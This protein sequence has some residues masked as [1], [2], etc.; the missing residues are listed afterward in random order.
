MLQR[1]GCNLGRQKR[2][3]TNCNITCW[4]IT[5]RPNNPFPMANDKNWAI[6]CDCINWWICTFLGYQEIEIRSYLI[7]SHQ[8][9]RFQRPVNNNRCHCPRK[10]SLGSN[11]V[12][13][14]DRARHRGGRKQEIKETS[15]DKLKTRPIEQAFGA[16]H[17]DNPKSA[18]P[19][20]LHDNGGLACNVMDGLVKN[21]FNKDKISW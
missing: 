13:D 11:K 6:M 20:N 8:G 19:Q 12:R 17:L 15:V 9:F 2:Q 3:I 7:P 4:E 16:Y 5:S 14:R 21:S 1:C 10:Q 18:K